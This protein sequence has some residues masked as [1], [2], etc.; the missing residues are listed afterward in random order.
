MSK[1]MKKTAGCA[2]FILLIA[3]PGQLVF[4]DSSLNSPLPSDYVSSIDFDNNGNQY[5]GT[6]GGGVVHV[7]DSVWTIWNESNTGVQINAV[8]LAI[9]DSGDD[10]GRD[11]SGF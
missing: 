10:L 8:R 5:V 11:L 7:R 4:A 6:S 3:F 1:K 9:R 2:I